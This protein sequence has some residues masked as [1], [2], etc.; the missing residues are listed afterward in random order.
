MSGLRHPAAMALTFATGL[1]LVIALALTDARGGRAAV[2]YVPISNEVSSWNFN[3]AL[4][5]HVLPKGSSGP[6]K[7]IL[8]GKDTPNASPPL[9]LRELVVLADKHLTVDAKGYPVC[10]PLQIE[11]KDNIT[12]EKQCKR[13]IVGRG[14]EQ[15]EVAIPETSPFQLKSSLVVFNGG[16]KRGVT[17]LLI[18][19][20]F[21]APVPGS[22]ITKVKI[23]KTHKGRYGTELTTSMPKIAGGF[24]AVTAFTI[25]LGKRFTY[26]G[27]R[28]SVISAECA[29]TRLLFKGIARFTNGSTESAT[30]LRICRQKS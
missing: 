30:N 28:K 17:T 18:H 19:G 5:P 22:I 13:A 24:G 2:G 27:K 11:A 23:K 4:T 25:K 14:S 6:A 20:Y 10:I 29:D 26:R 15:V 12:A 21:T 7:L 8:K 1:I 16:Y 9:G 3:A